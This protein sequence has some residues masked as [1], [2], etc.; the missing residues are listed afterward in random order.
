MPAADAPLLDIRDLRVEAPDGRGW[1]EIVKG[2][3]LTLKPGEVLGLIGESGAGKSTI[4][5]AAMAYARGGC[6]ISGGEVILKGEDILRLPPRRLRQLRGGRIAY[7]AQSAAAAF[8]PA[9]RIIDQYV[10]AVRFH[11]RTASADARR[12]AVAIYRRLRLPSPETIGERYPHELSGGQLQ[13]AMVAMAMACRP[14]IIVFDEPTTALDVTTQIEVLVAI[15]DVVAEAGVAA[16]YISHDLSVVAQMTDRVMVLRHGRTIEHG[17]TA[18]LIRAPREDYTR[19]LLGA[20]PSRRPSPSVGAALL[21]I[22]SLSARYGRAMPVLSEVSLA[23]P[24][25]AT[26][27]IV[28][29]SGSGKST[30][31]RIVSGLLAPVSG[32]ITFAGEPLAPL[33]RQR[34]QNLLWRIQAIHQIPDE[35]LNPGHRIRETI[36]RVLSL[37]HALRGRALDRRIFELLEMTEL[38]ADLIDRLPSELSGGQKQRVC[39]A[40][41]IAADPALIICDEVTSALDP[42]VARG[43]IDL[44]GRLQSGT[45]TSCIFIAHDLATVA[46]IADEIVVLKAGRVVESGPAAG[47]LA[48]P[49]ELY[50]QVLLGSVPTLDP[51][52][53]ATVRRSDVL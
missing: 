36:G 11:R 16:L 49:R 12:E 25:G 5:L 19:Q 24:K 48:D 7:V 14:D 27:A 34:P 22:E 2:V 6:R 4:G 9:R 10:E 3:S 15:K 33:V 42:L 38:D 41:A 45:G 43:I 30:L 8:N 32:R 50:T 13:R 28:G 20:R 29:E 44:L 52:W 21:Q 53:L 31:G 18:D 1:R 40:R 17:R 51:G 35:A 39:I 46:Q 47:L 37:R 26:V 23:V